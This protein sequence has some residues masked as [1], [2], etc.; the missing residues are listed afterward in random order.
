MLLCMSRPPVADKEN[1]V[2]HPQL[3][4]DQYSLEPATI[5]DGDIQE[6]D[7]VFLRK[8]KRNGHKQESARG[9]PTGLDSLKEFDKTYVNVKLLK[10]GD[11]EWIACHKL[12]TPRRILLSRHSSDRGVLF[13]SL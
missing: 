9:E 12:G 10:A 2:S 4:N 11:T 8:E 13:R 3:S 7:C 1:L 5:P 6:S